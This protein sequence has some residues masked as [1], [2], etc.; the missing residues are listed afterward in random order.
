MLLYEFTYTDRLNRCTEE[1]HSRVVKLLELDYESAD[2]APGYQVHQV[3][4]VD[5]MS[6]GSRQHT[7]HVYGEYRSD[8]V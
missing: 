6:D 5:T 1:I 2:W 4:E 7:F 8:A 3:F